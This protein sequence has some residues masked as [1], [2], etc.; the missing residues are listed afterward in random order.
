MLFCMAANPVA[1]TFA[2]GTLL[3][4][5]DTS[6]S[7]RYQLVIERLCPKAAAQFACHNRLAVCKTLAAQVKTPM[8]LFEYRSVSQWSKEIDG[9][10]TGGR[11]II[12]FNSWL[13]TRLWALAAA[14]WNPVHSWSRVIPGAA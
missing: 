9:R 1:I 3:W 13:P 7:K 11:K 8:Q 10:L 6:I 5:S 14:R 4:R 12:F 2:R